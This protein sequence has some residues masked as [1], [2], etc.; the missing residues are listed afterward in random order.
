V[1]KIRASEPIS[2]L[3]CYLLGLGNVNAASKARFIKQ[4]GPWYF[5][6]FTT[7]LLFMFNYARKTSLSWHYQNVPYGNPALAV[8]ANKPIYK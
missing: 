2:P 1:S 8:S 5:S 3:G 7:K 4:Q 6:I